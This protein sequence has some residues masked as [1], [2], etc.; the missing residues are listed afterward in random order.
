[1]AF[2]I[3][4]GVGADLHSIMFEHRM[5]KGAKWTA[6]GSG[7]LL[8][9]RPLSSHHR[10]LYSSPSPWSQLYH[11]HLFCSL[12]CIASSIRPSPQPLP[13]P[14]LSIRFIRCT[15]AVK[16]SRTPQKV[17][18]HPVWAVQAPLRTQQPRHHSACRQ[19]H[20]RAR[21]SFTAA[22]DDANCLQPPPHPAPHHVY[23]FHCPLGFPP[24]HR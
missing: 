4:P 22:K 13:P 5:Q 8:H 2:D 12:F 9:P 1:M 3:H 14:H 15:V 24:L 11:S 23:F 17:S 7:Q 6:R 20:A 18:V 21:R 19:M 16:A 10:P